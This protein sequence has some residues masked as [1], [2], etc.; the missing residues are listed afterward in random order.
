MDINNKLHKSYGCIRDC[1]IDYIITLL[2][3]HSKNGKYDKKTLTELTTIISFLKQRYFD[4]VRI[5]LAYDEGLPVNRKLSQYFILKTKSKNYIKNIISYEFNQTK[6]QSKEIDNYKSTL[7]DTIIS[8]NQDALCQHTDISLFFK[9]EILN[10]INSLNI[11]YKGQHDKRLFFIEFLSICKFEISERLF[12]YVKNHTLS[13]DSLPFTIYDSNHPL[14]QFDTYNQYVKN[15][16]TL[17]NNFI[18]NK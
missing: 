5:D 16:Y 6:L 14:I 12:D 15:R 17:I 2:K 4:Q 7:V 13:E 18:T 11:S 8:G 1:E 3:K 9:S 10:H